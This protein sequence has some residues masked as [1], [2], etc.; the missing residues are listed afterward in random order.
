MGSSPRVRSGLSD[1]ATCGRP[2]GI[3]SACAERSRWRSR[4]LGASRD[5]LRVCGAVIPLVILRELVAGSSPRVRSGRCPRTTCPCSSGIISACAER[6]TRCRQAPSLC[7][8]HLRVCGAV[9]FDVSNASSNAGSSPR[10]RSGLR[11]GVFRRC[12]TG[13]ISA[14]AERS[15]PARRPG[16]PSGDH[17]RVCGAVLF[18]WVLLVKTSGSSPRVRSGRW[19][20]G[21]PHH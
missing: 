16:T 8:D 21:H 18:F 15:P 3:I 5:H 12:R 19:C 13:I 2:I 1:H 17:L 11:R 9:P 10:V 20:A 6:S 4:G 7:R 14:C